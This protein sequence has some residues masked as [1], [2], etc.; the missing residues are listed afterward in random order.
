VETKYEASL[1]EEVWRT[2][3]L[4]LQAQEQAY[5][6]AKETCWWVATECE[7]LVPGAYNAAL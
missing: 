4:K 5:K 7:I 3:Q 1:G 2:A 6:L